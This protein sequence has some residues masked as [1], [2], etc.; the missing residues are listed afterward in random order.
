M[1]TNHKVAVRKSKAVNKNLKS[2]LLG[3]IQVLPEKFFTFVHEGISIIWMDES[4]K[5]PIR[6]S[7]SKS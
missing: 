1:N 2:A 4:S 5:N 7:R 3:E 6:G